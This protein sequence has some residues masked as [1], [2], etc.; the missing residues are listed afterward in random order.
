MVYILKKRCDGVATESGG[1]EASDK[2]FSFSVCVGNYTCKILEPM[3]VG[4]L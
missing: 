2:R 4:E 3:F 1:E